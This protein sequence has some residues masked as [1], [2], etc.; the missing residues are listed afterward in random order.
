MPSES[1]RQVQVL[2]PHSSSSNLCDGLET[3]P[4]QIGLGAIFHPCYPS[5]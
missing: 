4:E 1:G 5:V 2:G 3:L